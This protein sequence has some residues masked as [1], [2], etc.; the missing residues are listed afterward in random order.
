MR[1][2]PRA[3]R[4]RIGIPVRERPDLCA[5]TLRSLA[6]GSPPGAETW[7]FVDGAG[8]HV[9]RALPREGVRIVAWDEPRGAPACFNALAADLG[10]HLFVLLE[11]G[12][13]VGPGWLERMTAAL[14]ADPARGVAGPSTN[15][16]WNAQAVF[17]RAG[18]S[19]AELARTA[20]QAAARFGDAAESLAP[21]HAL[22]D[23]CW[24]VDRR[25]VE[26][27][28][29]V[30]EGYGLGPC[31]E[32][33]YNARAERG[34]FRGVWAKGAYVWRAPATPRR[35]AEEAALFDASRR[36][37][38]DRFC[39][40][41]RG[42]APPPY[43]PHCR[44]EACPDFAPPGLVE[45]RIPIAVPPEVPAVA[46]ASAPTPAGSPI[47]SCAAPLVSC[48]V[49]TADRR[50]FLPLAIE[51]FLRQDYGPRELVVLDDGRD[52][53]GDLV[54]PDPRIRYLRAARFTS[55]GAKRNQACRLA[56]GEV[57]VHWDDDDWSAPW[58]LSYQVSE[59]FTRGASVCG[60]DRLWFYD[61]S[62][63][64]AWRYRYPGG[65]TTWLSGN[66]FCFRRALWERHPFPDLTVGEDT[67][68]VR[69]AGGARVL[70]LERDDFFVARVH[71]GNTS[72]K[73]TAGSCWTRGDP[74]TVRALLGD[75]LARFAGRPRGAA[76]LVS[77]LLPTCGRRAF[78]ALAVAR[79]LEQDY[80][81]KELVVVDDGPEPVEDLV[82]GVASV[83]YLRLPARQ[84][85]GRK[86]NL[87]AA[88]SRG[89]VLVQW[90][91]DD[92]Y[93]PERLRRQAEPILA[94][95]A[96]LTALD[97]RWVMGLPEAE[98]WTLTPQLHR[99]MFVGDVHGGTLAF[100][101]AAWER[102]IR[103]PDASLAE[104]A[105]FLRTAQARGLRLAR[106]PN[107][108]LFVY[109]RHA[110]NAWR[111][112]LGRYLDPAAWRR[113]EP[114]TRLAPRVI[115]AYTVAAR[116]A[117]LQPHAVGRQAGRAP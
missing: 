92:W 52:P 28:G 12:A 93:G 50:A 34:G 89:E 106:V 78:V 4:I 104:D 81:A 71:P 84:T 70:P 16:G 64:E 66:T 74:A 68:W 13:R 2:L 11:N 54:P 117:E 111:F 7:I 21:L 3:R 33:D 116:A 40:R 24:A 82:A 72:P 65:R 22:G 80:P 18:G 94:G 103:Y 63:D 61:P 41:R 79:F 15:R 46:A 23:F 76:P 51:T 57:L 38:Q 8:P 67:R 115:E 73:Q 108:E 30:D 6:R 86:R 112:P 62:R 14:D 85:I 53:V 36:R 32:M 77:C 31:W 110:S 98:F 58:R 102:G 69:E 26:R 91:D 87:A 59:L 44:G 95:I 25:V 1:A 9:M 90:D 109:T 37:Y 27:I 56:R 83:R 19:D 97:T 88:E 17:A 48:L 101:R 99:R 105:A 55:L 39:A 29:G 5:A 100:A 42:P 45:L 96:D 114:P 43:E 60:L 107:E 75:D 49:P 113:I 35:Q 20:A 10:A 47:V